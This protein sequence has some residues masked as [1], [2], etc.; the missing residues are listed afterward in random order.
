L[1]ELEITFNDG[2]AVIIQSGIPGH[3]FAQ[4]ANF[5]MCVNICADIGSSSSGNN[6][7]ATYNTCISSCV[8]A[9]L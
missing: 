7:N 2:P 1:G 4:L 9:K 3:P 6:N 5:K 8:G